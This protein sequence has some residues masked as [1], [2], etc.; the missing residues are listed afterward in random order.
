M[1]HIS[2]NE[3]RGIDF[4]SPHNDGCACTV[5]HSRPS[6]G[7]RNAIF[8]HFRKQQNK[9]VEFS[10]PAKCSEVSLDSRADE[11][12]SS[13]LAKNRCRQQNTGGFHRN[14]KLVKLRRK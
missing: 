10:V 11:T 12:H 5:A 8:V 4:S 1:K 2:S 3:F 14:R 7:E 9:T 13:P 6:I